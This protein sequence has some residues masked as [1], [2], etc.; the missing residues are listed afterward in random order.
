[1]VGMFSCLTK[2]RD[3]Y[4]SISQDEAIKYFYGIFSY[5]REEISNVR[6]EDWFKVVDSNN[7]FN[8]DKEDLAL[9]FDRIKL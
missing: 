7:D 9:Y 4:S 2:K 6:G 1:M 3:G 8:I 5:V